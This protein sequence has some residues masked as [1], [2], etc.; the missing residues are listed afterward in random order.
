MV[1]NGPIWYNIILYGL[2]WLKCY[3]EDQLNGSGVTRA[4]GLVYIIDN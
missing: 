4:P 1:Q 3:L 2:I